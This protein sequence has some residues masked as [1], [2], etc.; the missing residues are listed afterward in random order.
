MCAVCWL[1]VWGAR[2]SKD[3]ELLLHS[4]FFLLVAIKSRWQTRSGCWEP[5]ASKKQHTIRDL[6]ESTLELNRPGREHVS[7]NLG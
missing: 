6:C 2:L 3:A 4:P 7:H 5:S 1:R